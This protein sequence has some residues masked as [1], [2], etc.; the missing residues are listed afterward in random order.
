M[1][2]SEVMG[3]DKEGVMY[4]FAPRRLAAFPVAA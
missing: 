4:V 3:K 1:W 2:V